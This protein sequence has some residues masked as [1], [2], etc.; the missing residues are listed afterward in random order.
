MAGEWEVPVTD[1]FTPA[2]TLCLLN[3]N[4]QCNPIWASQPD[5]LKLV[6]FPTL[7]EEFTGR[8]HV[9]VDAAYEKCERICLHGNH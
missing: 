7:Q 6:H 2:K 9:P 8:E 5:G 4:T 1:N 3:E